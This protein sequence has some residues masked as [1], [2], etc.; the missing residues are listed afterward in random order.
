M[1]RFRSKKLFQVSLL[2]LKENS[3]ERSYC[4]YQLI[5]RTVPICS[6]DS[7]HIQF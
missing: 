5:K 7:Q 3:W 1:T 6:K 4:K 2:F